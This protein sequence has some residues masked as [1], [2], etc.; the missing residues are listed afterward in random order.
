MPYSDTIDGRMFDFG[1]F[2]DRI[3]HELPN[4]AKIVEVGSAYGKSALYL[5]EKHGS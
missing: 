2:Y 1:A 4:H 3:V 5:A